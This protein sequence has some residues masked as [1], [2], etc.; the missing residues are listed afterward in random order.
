MG[1][2]LCNYKMCIIHNPHTKL[3][4]TWAI[5]TLSCV[6]QSSWHIREGLWELGLAVACWQC[7]TP[8]RDAVSLTR[9]PGTLGYGSFQ[10]KPKAHSQVGVL[11][12][13]V[14][15]SFCERGYF[16]NALPT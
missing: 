11:T 9:A 2:F 6:L 1:F 10:G 3:A 15:F 14:M 7:N 13:L 8:M 4:Y 5:L 16:S 12:H